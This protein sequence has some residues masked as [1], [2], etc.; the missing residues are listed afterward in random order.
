MDARNVDSPLAGTDTQP[1]FGRATDTSGVGPPRPSEVHLEG[2]A[3]HLSYQVHRRPADGSALVSLAE[4]KWQECSESRYIR[5]MAD[6]LGL[7]YPSL[8]LKLAMH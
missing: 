7:S 3:P 1:A 8:V 4:N 5:P 2:A 6:M